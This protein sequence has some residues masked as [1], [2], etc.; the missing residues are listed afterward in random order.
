M[1]K[2][3]LQVLHQ[4][5]YGMLAMML[6]S[7]MALQSCNKDEPLSPLQNQKYITLKTDMRTLWSDHMNWTYATVDAF[8]HAPNQ[9]NANLNRLLQN[10]QDIGNAIKPYYGQAAGDTL[11]ALLTTHIQLAVPVL[12]AAQN[13]DQTALDVA[14]ANWNANAKDIA[15]FL[16]AANPQNWP[17]S[18]TEPMMQEHISSTTTYAVDLLQE[19]Y[20]QSIMNFQHAYD[21]MMM[22]ADILAE[23]IA[24]Q[25]PDKF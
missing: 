22:L 17:T 9:L 20:D 1:K 8:Y 19:N 3:I 18:A 14:L 21:H 15:D 10:Q 6:I 25:F 12:T 5:K 16:S 24:K 7:T 13:G 11:A 23:G 2:R 4:H